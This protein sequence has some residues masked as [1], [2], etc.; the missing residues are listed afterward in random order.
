MVFFVGIYSQ[1]EGMGLLLKRTGPCLPYVKKLMMDGY[2]H[3]YLPAAGNSISAQLGTPVRATGTV[4]KRQA[5][6]PV[7]HVQNHTSLV[8]L[9]QPARR[10]AVLGQP[11]SIGPQWFTPTVLP[12]APH[13]PTKTARMDTLPYPTLSLSFSHLCVA[14][15]NLHVLAEGSVENRC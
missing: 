6:R 3:F 2:V 15:R 1:R 10:A 11:S 9:L 7:H 8:T 12:L 4:W 14:G 13:H 5:L